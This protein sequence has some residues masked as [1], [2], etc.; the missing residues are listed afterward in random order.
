MKYIIN[1]IISYQDEDGT[2]CYMES[3]DCI[4]FP[5]AAQRLMMTILESEGAILNRDDLLVQVWGRYGLS[6]S[7]NSLNQYLSLI[8][9][10][11][12]TFGC[13]SFIETLPK[14]GIQLNKD[15]EIRKEL[16]SPFLITE[17]EK[18]NVLKPV[19]GI[20]MRFRNLLMISST[21]IAF[22][23][24]TMIVI[25]LTDVPVLDSQYVTTSLP[26]G[27]KLVTFA[28]LSKKSLDSITKDVSAFIKSE[29]YACNSTTTLYFDN[30]SS[31]GRGGNART[32][33][34]F[35]DT[36]GKGNDVNCANY[37]YMHK[38]H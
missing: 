13:E 36:D 1:N 32:L 24:S 10:S 4:N 11:L 9:R 27:C 22:F 23:V 16:G 14:V 26:E 38:P 33:I 12:S 18:N 2:L 29:G 15:V 31:Q 35:C 21:V 37:Y 30:I 28:V 17:V 3:G 25:E 6:G 7:S 34:S 5:I 20:C 19:T 8:R